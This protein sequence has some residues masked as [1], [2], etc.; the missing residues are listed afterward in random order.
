M[1]KYIIL[2]LLSMS[3]FAD[4]G[5]VTG[6]VDKPMP[7]WFKESFL[8]IADDIEEASESNKHVMI[9]L[10]LDGCP[11]CAKMVEDFE[12]NKEFIKQYFDTIAI[13]I[14]GDKEVAINSMETL[15]EKEFA[16]RLGVQYTPTI[17]FLDKENNIVG[18]TNGYRNPDRMQMMF[19]YIKDNK[20][21]SLSFAQYV[22]NAT[23]SEKYQLESNNLFTE[24][25]DL[26]TEG[27]PF[28]VI[29]EDDSCSACEY[30]HNTTLKNKDI[31]TELHKYRVVRFDAKSSEKMTTPS[32]IKMSK[33]D[34]AKELDMTYR[35]G[36]VLFD[37]GE[38]VARVDGFLYT[39]HLATILRFVADKHYETMSFNKYLAQRTAELT[40]QGIDVDISK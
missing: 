25:C 37:K 24:T 9:F 14:R 17:I 12:Q 21:T 4:T 38:E 5:K 29:F 16:T 36:I 39:F 1:K 6:G 13:N 26:S 35:P 32:G 15:T 10:H 8:E 40:S 28:A 31:L 34:F 2:L 33:K 23:S 30:F 27:K 19:D 20:Y 7:S 3:V 22:E 11:Y 18:R